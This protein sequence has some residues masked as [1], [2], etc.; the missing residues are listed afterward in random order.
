M[1]LWTLNQFHTQSLNP[2]VSDTE[3]REYA[4]YITHPQNLPL[5]T[6]SE[7]PSDANIDYVE[8]IHKAGGP[9]FDSF[10]DDEDAGS[11]GGGVNEADL[12]DFWDFV[13]EKSDPLTVREEDR[14]KKRYKAYRQW[15]KGKSLFKQ[16]KVDPEF[17][18]Q[19]V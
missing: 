9:A 13:E 4:R 8:Y 2:H 18:R 17:S 14:D 7:L 3:T 16:S 19:G 11:F 10:E 5:V 6:S 1:H 12:Q 15:L